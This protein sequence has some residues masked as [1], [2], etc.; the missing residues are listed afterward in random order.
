M[1]IANLAGLEH[2]IDARRRQ[3]DML[4]SIATDETLNEQLRLAL[5]DLDEAAWWLHRRANDGPV[6]LLLDLAAWRLTT[7]V[8]MLR[9]EGAEVGLS[10]SPG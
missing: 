8:Q 10:D 7:A 5:R 6:N 3:A 9:M 4:L 2:R 1:T